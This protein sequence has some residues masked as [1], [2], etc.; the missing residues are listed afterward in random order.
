M[1][2]SHKAII[3][4]MTRKETAAFFGVSWKTVEK[5]EQLGRHPMYVDRMLELVQIIRS[6]KKLAENNWERGR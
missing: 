4:G 6:L 3:P 2:R 1:K 5:W